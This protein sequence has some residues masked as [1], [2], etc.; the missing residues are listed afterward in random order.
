MKKINEKLFQEIPFNFDQVS[1]MLSKISS[2][3]C[4]LF[5]V[6]SYGIESSELKYLSCT[7]LWTRSS[8][9]LKNV[10]AFNEMAV[11]TSLLNTGEKANG[12]ISIK[13]L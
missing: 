11:N 2:G 3:I 10:S 8:P 12:L 13:C 1:D 7:F 4:L 9:E 6:L 5:L